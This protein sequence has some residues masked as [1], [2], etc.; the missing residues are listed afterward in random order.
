MALGNLSRN[1]KKTV[2]VVISLSLAVVLLQITFIFA[3][4]FDM[5]K[6]LRQWV[7]SDFIVGNANYFQ[8][9]NPGFS[10]DQAVGEETIEAINE[11]TDITAAGRIY[12]MMG[13]AQTGV[14]PEY[15]RKN[16]SLWYSSADIDK[17]ISGAEKTEEGNIYTGVQLYGM[18][19]FPL[20]Q[21]HV[22]KGD[23][24]D[25][26][27]SSKKAIAAVYLT[28]DYDVVM[29]ETNWAKVGDQVKIDYVDEWEYFDTRTGEILTNPDTAD[30]EYL[31][32][33]VK[34]SYEEIYTVAA[35]VTMRNTMSY[36]YFGADE[37]V[38]NAEVFQR[39]TGT[40]GVMTYLFNTTEGANASTEAF[41][42]NYTE[43]VDPTLDYESKQAYVDQFDRFRNM[44][45]LMGGA[46]S[47][48]IGLVGI[49]NFLNAVLTS[50]LTRRREFAMLQSIGMTGKQLNS[51]LIYEGVLYTAMAAGLSLLL[52]IVGGPLMD[53]AMSSMFWF[54]T[55]HFSLLP[56][57]MVT[58]VFLTLGVVI[59]LIAYRSMAGQTIV[60]RLREV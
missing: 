12:G 38:L 54:F 18:E 37:F 42:K 5:D 47:F 27:D 11:S 55:Y 33:R 22:F 49:L 25:V 46:L 51:M 24:S 2:L 31:D 17:L 6:Y 1:K 48:I 7:V 45:L 53:T 57:L 21:L 36:R 29:P 10:Q 35:C 43:N 30:R 16:L 3:N 41:L 14:S 26:Y 60:E 32:A 19:K 58:P 20:D 23:L 15:Y 34:R 40:D 56:I 52:G 13:I 28:D 59:P 4:G 44:F 39:D 50:I 9:G 8:T